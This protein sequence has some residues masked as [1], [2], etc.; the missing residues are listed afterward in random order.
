MSENA[1]S[2]DFSSEALH[3]NI[4]ADW[5]TK[6]TDVLL[7]KGS[8][9][10][11]GTYYTTSFN[12]DTYIKVTNYATAS[13]HTNYRINAA[14]RSQRTSLEAGDPIITVEFRQFATDDIQHSF[15]LCQPATV[16]NDSIVGAWLRMNQPSTH[17]P[18]EYV[19]LNTS[20]GTEVS[21]GSALN[22]PLSDL[23]QA[24]S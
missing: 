22:S 7:T 13:C 9:E 20:D 21:I 10:D 23:V 18:D 24:I 16:R 5:H 3:T 17:Y 1:Y 2:P 11:D 6:L 4:A 14:D 19:I 15:I 8:V 12:D